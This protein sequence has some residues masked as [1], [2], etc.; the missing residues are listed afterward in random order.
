[1][2]AFCT[3]CGD[4]LAHVIVFLALLTIRDKE[5]HSGAR[6]DSGSPAV[7]DSAW[8]SAEDCTAPSLPVR[9]HCCACSRP[10]HRVD[11]VAAAV[12]LLKLRLLRSGRPPP[13]RNRGV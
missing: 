6:I 12:G 10:R 4:Q 5:N 13:T 8:L 9:G 11:A 2:A 7:N 3:L 1:M